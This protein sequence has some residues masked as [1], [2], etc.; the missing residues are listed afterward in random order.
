MNSVSLLIHFYLYVNK[1]GTNLEISSVRY[2]VNRKKEYQIKTIIYEING[3]KYV[4]KA[5]YTSYAV[6]HV[7]NIARNYKMYQNSIFTLVKPAVNGNEVI[8][9]FVEGESFDALILDN[10][11]RNNLEEF[12]GNLKW[13]IW[14]LDKETQID[15][16]IT[17]KFE[18]VFGSGYR[19]EQF[20]SLLFSNIDSTFDNMILNDNEVT[21]IDYEWVFDFPIPKEFIIYRSIN[22]FISKYE[23]PNEFKKKIDEL[24]YDLG[25]TKELLID[26]DKMEHHFTTYIGHNRQLYAEYL[27]D[28]YRNRNKDGEIT[29]EQNGYFQVFWS[30]DGT[31]NE[32]D[33]LKVKL[34]EE[35]QEQV[36]EIKLPET[37]L[38]S[39]RIDPTSF[40]SV[41]E[42][43]GRIFVDEKEIDIYEALTSLLDC[44]HYTKENKKLFYGAS[45]DPQLYLS[46]PLFKTEGIKRIKLTINYSLNLSDDLG[47]VLNELTS[48]VKNYK[49]EIVNIFNEKQKLKDN[50]QISTNEIEIL[51]LNNKQLLNNYELLKQ[52]LEEQLEQL[53]SER[54]QLYSEREQ[55]YKNIG[56]KDELIDK[57]V[58]SLPWKLLK[59]LRLIK[60]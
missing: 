25:I 42:M 28:V 40:P 45:N 29:F 34:L 10:I 7:L 50:L 27:K 48:T 2:S 51:T 24:L 33:S 38:E 56:K 44:A 3:E 12:V 26:F 30:S 14:L 15:F 37:P 57:I 46:H 1:G 60:I 20:K 59:K 47:F 52:D 16:K 18:E 9:P 58:T 32:K 21:M 36:I 19:F 23:L 35:K 5:P 43:K 6:N 31:L 11:N 39:I 54:E 17:P 22:G 41:F 13:F 55:L 8:F 49:N 53:Y 4:K